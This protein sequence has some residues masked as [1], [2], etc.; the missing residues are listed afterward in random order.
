MHEKVTITS[1]TKPQLC[2]FLLSVW[3]TQ[4]GLDGGLFSFRIIKGRYLREVRFRKCLFF[5]SKNLQ[6]WNGYPDSS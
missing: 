2:T 3:G 5:V 4:Y 6:R 1:Q